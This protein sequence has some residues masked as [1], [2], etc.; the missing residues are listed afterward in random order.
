MAIVE[1]ILLGI[2][3]TLLGLA[4]GYVLARWFIDVLAA[5]VLPDLGLHLLLTPG[6]LITV[7]VLGIAAVAITPVFGWRRLRSLNVPS[8]LRLME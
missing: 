5:R 2:F 4:G 8:A 6:S 7:G 3:S 1:S